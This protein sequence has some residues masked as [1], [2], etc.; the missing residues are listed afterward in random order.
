M[1]NKRLLV[2]L[3]KAKV[4]AKAKVKRKPHAPI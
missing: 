3:I 1:S 2:T 4:N